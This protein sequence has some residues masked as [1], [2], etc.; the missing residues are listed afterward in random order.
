LQRSKLARDFVTVETEFGKI[1]IK[2]GTLK[3]RIVNAKPEFS[4]C[5]SAAEKHNV[6]VKTVMEAAM[7]AYKSQS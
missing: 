3:G 6:A 5:V 1:R 4:Y 7:N 2:T